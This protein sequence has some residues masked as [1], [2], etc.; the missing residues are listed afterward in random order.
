MTKKAT[1]KQTVAARLRRYG[2]VTNLWA[3]QNNIWRLSHIVF[4][5][6]REG[7]PIALEY[8]TKNVGKNSHYRLTKPE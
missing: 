7:W 6:R 4:E 2:L 3:W 8:G 1:Q 5:L